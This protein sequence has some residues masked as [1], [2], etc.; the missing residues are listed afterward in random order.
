F[1]SQ[2]ISQETIQ[3]NPV[4]IGGT[5]CHNPVC[6]H[7]NCSG[8]D[9]MP[10]IIQA[11]Y[12]TVKEVP[13]SF[14]KMFLL[15]PGTVYAKDKCHSGCPNLTVNTPESFDIR[16]NKLVTS[17]PCG[18]VYITFYTASCEEDNTQ[19]IPDNYYIKEYIE[20]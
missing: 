10:E 19:L 11:V 17:F 5:P 15:T 12:K 18:T 20:K 8:T 1:Y 16:D 14:R 6:Q 2:A 4:T 3:L 13:R 7:P 9:C